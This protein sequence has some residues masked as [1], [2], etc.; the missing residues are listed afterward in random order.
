MSPIPSPDAILAVRRIVACP[1]CGAR[2]RSLSDTAQGV[3]AHC[4]GCGGELSTP[5]ATERTPAV[6]GRG[7]QILA[8]A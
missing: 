7:G 8:T 3:R 2:R 5:F 1:D 6:L 4:M